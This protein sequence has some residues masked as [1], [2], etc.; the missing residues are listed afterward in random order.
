MRGISGRLDSGDGI[1]HPGLIG[2]DACV[3][4]SVRGSID[5]TRGSG[6]GAATSA[7]RRRWPMTGSGIAVCRRVAPGISRFRAGTMTRFLLQRDLAVFIQREF[8]ITT[9][10]TG[11]NQERRCHD[12]SQW[13]ETGAQG[14]GKRNGAI[15]DPGSPGA[16]RV[17]LS[18]AG[19]GSGISTDTAWVGDSARFEH[20]H[21]L[22]H[23]ALEAPGSMCHG[24]SASGHRNSSNKTTM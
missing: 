18:A 8:G 12:G 10:T 5:R 6:M 3:S 13:R 14:T 7:T 20:H 19:M 22:H 15:H 17:V 16:R 23:E 2:L 24:R 1:D 9:A 4:T 21:D 11:G